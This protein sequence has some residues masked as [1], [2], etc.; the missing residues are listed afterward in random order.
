M[1]LP[2]VEKKRN[3]KQLEKNIREREL[4][5]SKSGNPLFGVLLFFAKFLLADKLQMIENSIILWR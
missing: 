2:D 3:D 1:F 4:G 5:L